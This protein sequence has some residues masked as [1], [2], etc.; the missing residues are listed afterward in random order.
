MASGAKAAAAALPLGTHAADVRR[1]IEMMEHLLERSV[2][3]PGT[4]AKVGL[5]AILGLVPV[6]GDL[7]AALLGLYIVW[8][9]RNLKMPATTMMRMVGNVGFDWLI[10]LVP[11]VGDAADFLFRSNTR[12]LR[13]IKRHLDRHHPGTATVHHR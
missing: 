3:I 9:A 2:P 12:N 8:E 10:G 11:V 5:D 1:R 13:L 7:I 4:K 6:G